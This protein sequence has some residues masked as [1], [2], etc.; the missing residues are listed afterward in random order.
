VG[1][2]TKALQRLASAGGRL[3]V[4]GLR[5]S[6]P[7]WTKLLQAARRSSA[8]LDLYLATQRGLTP[9]AKALLRENVLPNVRTQTPPRAPEVPNAG[10]RPGQNA[11]KPKPAPQERVPAPQRTPDPQN[12]PGSGNGFAQLNQNTRQVIEQWGDTDLRNKINSLLARGEDREIARIIDETVQGKGDGSKDY[13]SRLVN[14]LTARQRTLPSN[15]IPASKPFQQGGQNAIFEVQGRPDLVLKMPLQGQ[16]GN[17]NFEYRA[18][19]RLES[20][21]IETSLVGRTRI[22]TQNSLVQNRIPGAFSKA[23]MDV[24]EGQNLR[25]LVR[26]RTVNDLKRIYETLRNNNTNIKDFQFMVR[27]SDGAVIVIDPKSAEVGVPPSGNIE[28]IVRIFEGYL[29][30]NKR[31]G[32]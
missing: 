25:H 18:L 8:E 13:I 14:S 27:E 22:G 28:D 15:L 26:Q 4:G 20:M 24:R 9:E 7:Q 30:E 32:R 21:G 17:Y 31:L 23:I 19:L 16:S 29:S 1:L 12:N 10:A 6:R 2:E 11:P 5:L 3:A